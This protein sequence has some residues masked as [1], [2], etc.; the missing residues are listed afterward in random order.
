MGNLVSDVHN[1]TFE[2]HKNNWETLMKVNKAEFRIEIRR[3]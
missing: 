1:N 3:K 2:I